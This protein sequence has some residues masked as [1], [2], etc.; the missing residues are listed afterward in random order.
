[1]KDH[2]KE[3]IKLDLHVHSSY[4]DGSMPVDELFKLA[5][6][7][8][9]SH[10]AITDHDT[11]E[12][13]SKTIEAGEKYKICAIPG[14][15]LSAFSRRIQKKVHLLAYGLPMIAPCVLKLCETTLERRTRNT[16]RQI[17]ILQRNGYM[18]SIEEVQKVAGISTAL[19]KQ[20]IMHVLVNKGYT[21]HILSPLYKELFKENGIASGEIEYIEAKDAIEAIKADGGMVV[22]A[23]PA[24]SN[25]QELIAE[26]V[27]IGL[28]GLEVD[29]PKHS[30]KEK[31]E[32][33]E[34]A[35][36]YHLVPTGGSDFHGIYGDECV[37]GQSQGFDFRPFLDFLMMS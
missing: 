13:F 14:L 11:L 17:E 6:E 28:D 18:L 2:A 34:I 12:G 9:V 4:S 30:Q 35:G 33:I 10:L 31:E 3:F 24:M 16:L 1:M 23:H 29:H 36:R 32:L 5:L 27:Q 20:H 21:Q 37:I 8:G 25:C 7:K 19:Y 22:L 15:E 26:L